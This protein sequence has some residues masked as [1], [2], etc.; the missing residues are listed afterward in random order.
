MS[1]SSFDKK[2]QRNSKVNNFFAV[3]SVISFC[4]ILILG[5]VLFFTLP[6][7]EVSE[8]ERREL[9]SFPKFSVQNLLSGKFT[10]E[11]SI[12]ISDNFAFRDNLVKQSFELENKRGFRPDGIKVYSSDQ[13]FTSEKKKDLLKCID[14]ALIP[15]RISKQDLP[16]NVVGEKALPKSF[17]Q[18]LISDPSEYADLTKADLTGE[19]RGALFTIGDTA[20]EIFYGNKN[21]ANDYASTIN[22]FRYA[23]PANVRVFDMTVPTHFEFG[24]PSKYKDSYGRR[25]KPFIDEIYANLDAGITTVDAYSEILK[26]YNMGKYLYFRT[27]HHW[28]ALGAYYAYVAFAKSAGFEPVP[29]EQYEKGK[30]DKFLG[31]FYSSTYDTSLSQNPDFVEYF[32]PFT[33]YT[34]TNYRQDGVSTYKGSVIYKNIHSDSGGYLVFLGGDVPLSVIETENST[35]SSIIVFKESYGN[36]FIPFLLSHYDK[37]YVADIRTFPFSL[38]EYITENNISDVLFCNNIMTACSAARVM[39]IMNLQK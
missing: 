30:I 15:A 6:K 28:T 35:G 4:F 22:S 9:A 37:I 12:Y 14:S 8:I 29:I 33:N 1:N 7:K 11:L 34:M 25:Q 3:F 10:D 16:T 5:G 13:N 19:K 17:L 21:V 27:D 2:S 39:N 18:S 36:A 26:N 20:L 24:L 31:T 32:L 23:L 38:T